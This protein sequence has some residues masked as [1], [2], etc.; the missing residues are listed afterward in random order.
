MARF[1]N[2]AVSAVATAPSPATSGT[3]LV[4]SSGHGTRF[5]DV[6]FQLT[7]CPVGSAPTP[8]N[9]EIVKV[10]N[11]A[12]DTL[13][14]VRA[15]EGTTARSVVVGDQVAA[16]L[17]A[18][19]FAGTYQAWGS[20]SGTTPALVFESVKQ[21]LTLTTSG[22]TTFSASGYVQGSEIDLFITEGD[23]V[24]RT[25]AFPSWTWL[26]GVPASIAASKRMRINLKCT[27]TTAA[28]VFAT[29]AV[30]A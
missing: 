14:I 15:Q 11:V 30:E 18:A 21:N 5:P 24:L 16:T 22:N 13:T 23:A 29:Y 7:I 27:G 26:E 1:T 20:I 17:T 25:L 12:T 2:F 28:S 6:P 4:V 10:T 3:S 9:A 19:L 8:A